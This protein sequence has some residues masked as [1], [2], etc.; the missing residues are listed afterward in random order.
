MKFFIAALLISA[1]TVTATSAATTP[2]NTMPEIPLAETFWKLYQQANQL[3]INDCSNK[4]GRLARALRAAGYEADVL[5]IQPWRSRMQHAIVQI[6]KD[7]HIFYLD[8]VRGTRF[9]KV[10]NFGRRIRLIDFEDLDLEGTE[11]M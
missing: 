5:V 11:F 2:S 3:G 7:G 10:G 9:T 6:K 4:C 8:P 1:T